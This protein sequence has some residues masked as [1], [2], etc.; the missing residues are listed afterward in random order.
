M[1]SVPG[2]DPWA[3]ELHMPPDAPVGHEDASM[4]R[5][6]DI[7]LDCAVCSAQGERTCE[8]CGG[9]GSVGSGRNRRRCEVCEGRGQVTCTTCGGSGGMIGSPIVWGR[10][11]THEEI[12]TTGTDTLP[13]EVAFDLVERA[14]PGELLH[15]QEGELLT[16][17]R[18]EGGY[19][20]GST[21]PPEVARTTEAL[22][23]E[24]SVGTGARIRGQVLELRRTT[25]LEV[26]LEGGEA[27]YV[28]GEPP[29]VFPRGPL[30]TLLGHIF[31]FLAR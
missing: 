10:I 17:V 24:P 25:V 6:A 18:L 31:P 30:T 2:P 20:G 21:L 27:V 23:R 8:R 1:A 13:L 26:R 7:P 11:D 16:D 14:A 3:T 12:R 29:K 22:L 5:G 9:D 28:W 19:R 15:R 4:L